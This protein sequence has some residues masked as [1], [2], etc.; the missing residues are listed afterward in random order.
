MSIQLSKEEKAR[1]VD[2]RLKD[3]DYVKHCLEVYAKNKKYRQ[4]REKKV[5]LAIYN[6]RLR[7]EW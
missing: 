6:S 2:G 3:V 1:E 7:G 4:L 5:K